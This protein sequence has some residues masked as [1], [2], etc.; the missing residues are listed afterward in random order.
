MSSATLQTRAITDFD[1]YTPFP[2]FVT[3]NKDIWEFIKRGITLEPLVGPDT[4]Y[5]LVYPK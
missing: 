3:E 1:V 4:M 5:V 2:R